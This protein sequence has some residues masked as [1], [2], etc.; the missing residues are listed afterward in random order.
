M[1]MG[2]PKR[3]DLRGG[4]GLI[5]DDV[6]HVAFP[7]LKCCAFLRQAI[8]VIVDFVHVAVGMGQHGKPVV[9]RNP[10]AR[11][12]GRKCASEIVRC[13]PIGL[14]TRHYLSIV[15]GLVE[16]FDDPAQRLRQTVARQ[17]VALSKF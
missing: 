14:E 1:V 2:A 15:A 13:R 17:P 11:Q 7:D 9:A 16:V 10:K 3:Q 4:L 6:A 8:V 12:S 5:R